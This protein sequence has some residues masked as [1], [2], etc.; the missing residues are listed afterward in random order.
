MPLSDHDRPLSEHE[1]R[2]LAEIE[3]DLAA[4]VRS[5][6]RRRRLTGCYIAVLT[7]SVGIAVVVTGVLGSLIGGLTVYMWARNQVMGHPDRLARGAEQSWSAT[8]NR[9]LAAVSAVTHFPSGTRP[10]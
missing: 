7:L 8:G 6:Q 3:S 2:A 10:G 5:R 1:R 9:L 4:A